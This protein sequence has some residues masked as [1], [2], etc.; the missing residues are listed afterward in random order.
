MTPNK[1][2]ADSPY[3]GTRSR[4]RT[5][6]K[7]VLIVGLILGISTWIAQEEYSSSVYG[8]CMGTQDP[9]EASQSMRDQCVRQHNRALR[10]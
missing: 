9:R 5:G 8:K 1:P 10:D 7:A 3:R 2:I 4:W 6:V